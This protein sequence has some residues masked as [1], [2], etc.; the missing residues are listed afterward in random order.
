M[1]SPDAMKG[2][3]FLLRGKSVEEDSQPLALGVYKTQLDKD[4]E[5]CYDIAGSWTFPPKL[6]SNLNYS[7]ILENTIYFLLQKKHCRMLDSE[8]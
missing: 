8:I 4:L 7:I 2:K 1:K 5:I 3:V 6:S